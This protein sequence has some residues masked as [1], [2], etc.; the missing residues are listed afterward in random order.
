MHS[1]VY[2]YI[3]I[4][5]H[6]SLYNFIKCKNSSKVVTSTLFS[7][8]ILYINTIQSIRIACMHISIAEHVNICIYTVYKELC[9]SKAAIDIAIENYTL[10]C[11]YQGL[12]QLSF[13]DAQ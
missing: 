10:S 6:C 3:H 11:I 9:V 13:I 1:I 4:G 7:L 12:K 8:V 5:Q 2:I